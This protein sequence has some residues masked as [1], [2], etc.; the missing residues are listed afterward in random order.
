MLKE[1]WASVVNDMAIGRST[2]DG[3]SAWEFRVYVSI[4]APDN[5]CRGVLYCIMM[6]RVL[7][8]LRKDRLDCADLCARQ[9][10]THACSVTCMCSSQS[11]PRFRWSKF[12]KQCGIR[13]SLGA[14]PL[15]RLVLSCSALFSCAS[16]KS[17]N[18]TAHTCSVRL[19]KGP[20][21]HPCKRSVTK[22]LDDLPTSK[23]SNN[24][25][26]ALVNSHRLVVN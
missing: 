11:S 13:L 26:T 15:M 24:C 10:L 6:S 4:N 16:I 23:G 2:N 25:I 12:Q 18:E 7:I 22:V 20:S 9:G 14:R 17:R 5:G 3:S 21:S 8:V 1:G 19:E